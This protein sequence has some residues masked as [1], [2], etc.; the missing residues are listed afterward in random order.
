MRLAKRVAVVAG[1]LGVAVIAFAAFGPESAA[2]HP[3]SGFHWHSG[4]LPWGEFWSCLYYAS[5]A[6]TGICR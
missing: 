2:A 5:G 4:Y 3:S 6:W 1:A